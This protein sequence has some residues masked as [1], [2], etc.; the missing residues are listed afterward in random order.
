MIATLAISEKND[1]GKS[2]QNPSRIDLSPAYTQFVEPIETGRR[3]GESCRV[4]N[5]HTLIHMT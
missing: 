3:G 2:Y 5:N 4:H 1:D